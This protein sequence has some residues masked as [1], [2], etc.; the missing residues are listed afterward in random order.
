MKIS[1][2]LRIFESYSSNFQKIYSIIL[3]R[4]LYGLKKLGRIWY[5]RFSEYL[6]NECYINDAIYPCIFIKKTASEFVIID[7]ML[8]T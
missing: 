4:S 5:Y 7:D 2:E 1:E 8:M 3:Q 6:T